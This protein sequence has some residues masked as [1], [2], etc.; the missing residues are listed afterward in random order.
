[1]VEQLLSAFGNRMFIMHGDRYAGG[2]DPGMMT[3]DGSTGQ[4]SK[5]TSAALNPSAV[6]AVAR[7]NCGSQTGT[8]TSQIIQA[9]VVAGPSVLFFSVVDASHT[10]TTIRNKLFIF[11][12]NNSSAILCRLI[13]TTTVTDSTDHVV[14]FSYD[15]S[16]GTTILRMDGNDVNDTGHALHVLTTGT[17]AN[18]AVSY[19][20]NVGSNVIPDRHFNGDIGYL[21]LRYDAYL[22]NWSDFMD[23]SNPKE[24]DE[25]GW[26]EWGAQPR[27]WNQF[28]T[29]DDN[30][31]SAGNM[32][33]NGT[34]TGPA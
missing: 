31:G 29:M 9:D 4:Y 2:Y 12:Q 32:T 22:T 30:K 33:E 11:V 8:T 18:T 10:D 15:P 24:L 34:I 13:S 17:I 6:T 23:G 28:G 16:A 21:G 26:T 3:F 19:T 25:S 27:L 7:F 20:E 1:M 14:F 5:S